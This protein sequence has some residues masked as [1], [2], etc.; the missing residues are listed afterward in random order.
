MTVSYI[1]QGRRQ[2]IDRVAADGP[3]G[4]RNR[5][6]PT[7]RSTETRSRFPCPSTSGGGPTTFLYT[8]E[9]AGTELKLHTS[10]MDMPI[11]IVLKKS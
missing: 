5:I 7:E 6:A 10:F 8:G 9:L 3:D 11:D 2:R 4:I 1:V